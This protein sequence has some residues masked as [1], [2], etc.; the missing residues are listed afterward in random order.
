MHFGD[1]CEDL[2]RVKLGLCELAKLASDEWGSLAWAEGM[3]ELEKLL[4]E[5]VEPAA[6]Q[7]AVTPVVLAAY[8]GVFDKNLSDYKLK[9]FSELHRLL[10]FKLLPLRIKQAMNAAAPTIRTMVHG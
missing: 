5:H 10:S 6:L 9:R 8:S 7:L 4:I 2:F 1:L 3:V